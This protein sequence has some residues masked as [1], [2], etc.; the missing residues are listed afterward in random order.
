MQKILDIVA[1]VGSDLQVKFNSSKKNFLT[2]N[3]HLRKSKIL[4]V[5]NKLVINGSEIEEVKSM[6]YLGNFLNNS[7]SNRDHLSNRI[8]LAAAAISSN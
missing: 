6:K 4:H 2:I 1:R 7:L 3:M 8:K 5:N